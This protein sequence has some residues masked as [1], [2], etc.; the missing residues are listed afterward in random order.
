MTKLHVYNSL[1]R[2]LEQ[3]EP[4]N[5]GKVSIYNC[6]PTVYKRQHIGNMRRFLFSDFLRRSLEYLGYEV[7]EITNIT[8]VG[9]LTED[10]IDAGEDKMEKE[11]RAQKATPV[12]IANKQIKLFLSDLKTI[13]IQSAHLYPRATEH[14]DQMQKLTIELIE[15]GHAY[16]TATGIYFDVQSFPDYGKLSGNTLEKI[17]PGHRVDVREE[18]KHPADFAL[19]IKDDAHLQKW[20][21]PWGVGYPGWH[22]ECSAMSLAYLSAPIDIHTGGEDNRFPHHENEIAQSEAALGKPFA[23][24]WMHNRHLQIGGEKMAKREGKLI[25]L[26]TVVEHGFSPLAFRLFVFG[27]HY[28]TKVDFSWESLSAAQEH[29]ETIQQLLRQLRERGITP[30]APDQTVLESFKAVLADDLNTPQASAIFAEYIR[31][32]NSAVAENAGVD[33]LAQMYGTLQSMDEV[34]GILEPLVRELD[35]EVIPEEVRELADQREQARVDK[36]F[37]RADVLRVQI[38][39]QGYRVEDASSGPRIIKLQ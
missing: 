6:G 18:K 20:D 35:A 10:D 38:E 34:V 31:K 13:N 33:L 24:Y 30:A 32:T 39:A 26:D 17:D 25:T 36:D 5:P 19:W 4:V 23:R 3:F 15:K 7:R 22:I 16:E 28:R 21:S 14:I 1:T 9:H 37:A 2:Q 8:D 12:D 11:A 29:L 27:T